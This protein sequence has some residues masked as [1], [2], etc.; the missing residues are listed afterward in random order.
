GRAGRAGSASPAR[1]SSGGGPLIGV[2]RV[3][4]GR[5]AAAA[6]EVGSGLRSAPRQSPLER[7]APALRTDRDR[8]LL[9]CRRTEYRRSTAL[10]VRDQPAQTVPVDELEVLPLGELLGRG[11]VA[12]AGNE[13]SALSALVLA[14]A[15]QLAQRADADIADL[16]VLRLHDAATPGVLEHEVYPAVCARPASVRDR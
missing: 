3:P 4:A 12:P 7:P 2:S 15:P 16:P 9:R 8:L 10:D 6:E 11:A 14:N 13:D 1:A 5:V